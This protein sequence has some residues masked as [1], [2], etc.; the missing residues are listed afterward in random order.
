M[1]TTCITTLVTLCLLC[2]ASRA[3]ANTAQ[4]LRKIQLSPTMSLI[5]ERVTEPRTI[6]GEPLSKLPA[7]VVPLNPDQFHPIKESFI[8][9]LKTGDFM[10][11][12]D[13]AVFQSIE[14]VKDSASPRFA[15]YNAVLEGNYLHYLFINKGK[16]LLATAKVDETG[17]VSNYQQ[18]PLPEKISGID[19]A[20]FGK[21]KDGETILKVRDSGSKEKVFKFSD[22]GEAI[23]VPSE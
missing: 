19:T 18:K 2:A 1:K 7:G 17:S 22:A 13:R 23:S 14:E 8:I 12:L 16:V 3:A 11:E 21:N 6:S 20:R 9:S 5:L 10:V 15:V 4:I